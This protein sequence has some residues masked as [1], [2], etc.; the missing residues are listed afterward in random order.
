MYNKE[1][2]SIDRMFSA[3]SGEVWHDWVED[4]ILICLTIRDG[5]R[6]MVQQ[7]MTREEAQDLIVLM[8]DLIAEYEEEASKPKEVDILRDLHSHNHM[9]HHH[10]HST[11][12]NPHAPTNETTI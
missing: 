3:F 9:E 8:N 5:G 4:D 1:T 11:E 2:K 12:T 6:N 7:Y 10:H